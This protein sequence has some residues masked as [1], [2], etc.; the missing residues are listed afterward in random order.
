MIGQELGIRRI[1]TLYIQL[2]YR[3]NFS[4]GHCFHG[5]K[6]QD[7]STIGRE[8]VREVMDHFRENYATSHV[9][10]LGGEPFLHPDLHDTLQYARE[11]GMTTEICTNGHRFTQAKIRSMS[12]NIDDLRVSI[13]G[14]E[15]VHDRLR[16]RGSFRHALE[17]VQISAREGIRTGVTSTVTSENIREIPELARTAAENG[18]TLM[19]LH[20]LRAVGNAAGRPGLV[21]DDLG[22]LESLVAWARET[23]IIQVAF[24]DDL[25]P[26]KTV[27]C[28]PRGASSIDRI[29]MDP[30]FGLTMS[31]KAVGTGAQAF[32]WSRVNNNVVRV[33]NDRNEVVLGIPDVRYEN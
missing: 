12:Q 15:D 32:R 2:L 4:C 18:A 8:D 14:L 1:D 28:A 10:L 29:E 21:C 25:D 17:T 23:E 11:N 16:R 33:S 9:V 6:L 3:C 19:K 26:S 20:Q 13:D 22:L 31:C 30:E 7:P 5:E 24:D 27:G